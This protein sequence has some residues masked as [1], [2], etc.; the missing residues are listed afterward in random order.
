LSRALPSPL[1]SDV[2]LLHI[3]PHKTGTTTLQGAFHH[4]RPDL[5]QHGVHY[6]GKRRQPWLAA[7]AATGR[8]GR[9]G[10]PPAANKHWRALV[11]E[12]QAEGARRRVIVSSE[13]FADADDAGIARIVEDLGGD[14]VQ[15]LITLRPL[16]KILPS[17][18]Q[19]AVRNGLPMPYG[20]WLQNMLKQPGA[21]SVSP[22]F[23]VRHAHD[24]LV[25]RWAS[26][27]GP[28]RLTVLVLDETDREMFLRAVES[29]LGLPE[30]VLVPQPSLS[31][32]SLTRGEVEMLRVLNAEF[33]REKWPGQLYARYVRL[34]AIKHMLE[35][36]P[37]PS[38]PPISTPRWALERSAEIGAAAGAAIR[39][40][41]VRVVG[42]LDS[43]GR[44]TLPA[45][46]A[47]NDP[48]PPPVLPAAAAAQALIGTIGAANS[49]AWPDRYSAMAKKAGPK[50][51]GSD[52]ES[53][54]VAAAS[55]RSLLK[56]VAAR[57]KR[58]LRHAV[59]SRIRR[60]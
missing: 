47:K 43:L 22:T 55:A 23:W 5:H 12:V 42:D 8:R 41:G 30:R 53:T 16:A 48:V 38:E 19:Q 60:R 21:A 1:P 50:Q 51:P 59:G 36:E 49:S 58:R 28:D 2:V 17:Q 20:K 11:R 37:D 34:G 45:A 39:A 10:D 33:K 56:V 26:V 3:G 13:R 32:R 6:A 27:V 44:V 40:S 18:W 9:P 24:Q 4:A 25:Q 54:P 15:I 29:M 52:L 57:G 7:L 31:N 46:R 35:R 14:R